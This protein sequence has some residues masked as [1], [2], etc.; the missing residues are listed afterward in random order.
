MRYTNAD[1]KEID[2]E[3]K[4]I[5]KDSWNKEAQT[6]KKG[7]FLFGA[8]GRGKTYTLYAI[9]NRL[10]KT[11]PHRETDIETWQGLLFEMKENFSKNKFRDTLQTFLEKDII[12][13]DDV[14]VEKNT[15]WS[16]EMFYMVINEIYVHE[17]TLFIT[18]N[19][20]LE[21]FAQKYGDR[22]VDRLAELCDFHEMKGINRR[23]Q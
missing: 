23:N 18:T 15:E 1:M 12:F 22:I 4:E 5:L 16:Q 21:D 13:I 2:E 11:N 8:T 20:S 10:R 19:L 7:L 9:R 3:I 6:F 17:K 14:G